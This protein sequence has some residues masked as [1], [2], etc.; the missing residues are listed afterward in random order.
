MNTRADVPLHERMARERNEQGRNMHELA[1]ILLT[2]EW[3]SHD[4]EREPFEW[5]DFTSCGVHFPG[6]DTFEYGQG[7]QQAQNIASRAFVDPESTLCDQLEWLDDLLVKEILEEENQNG[8]ISE[9]LLQRLDQENS[10]QDVHDWVKESQQNAAEHRPA[11]DHP[12]AVENR[13]PRKIPS[14]PANSMDHPIY[15]QGPLDFNAKKPNCEGTTK[16]DSD[17][18]PELHSKAHQTI[19]PG[20]A[21]FMDDPFEGS[22]RTRSSNLD[23]RLDNPCSPSSKK[24]VGYESCMK[25]GASR[26]TAMPR[27]P[28]HRVLDERKRLANRRAAAR[29][30]VKK[31]LTSKL[32]R[33]EY[34]EQQKRLEELQQ[35]KKTIEM[36][37]ESAQEEL[38]KLQTR[39]NV[40]SHKDKHKNTSSLCPNHQLRN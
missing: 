25:E 10:M 8:N 21:C 23:G 17:L 20:E 4:E 24:E 27:A 30:H 29:S 35:E 38:C 18:I 6:E 5:V 33:V 32:L 13:I 14:H 12:Q 28:K 19:L 7:Q 2:E 34:S 1:S 3:L 37:I 15:L 16:Q 9:Q 36:A 11:R 39:K 26:S 22:G 31:T 40:S